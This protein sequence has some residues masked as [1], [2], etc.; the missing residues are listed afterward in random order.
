M[1]TKIKNI[2]YPDIHG[3]LDAVQPL[4][5]IVIKTKSGLL[6]PVYKVEDQ[7]RMKLTPVKLDSEGKIKSLQ[8]QNSTNIKTSVGNISAEFITFYPSGNLRRLFPLNGKL[9]GFWSED[10]EYKLAKSI[11][12]PTPIGDISVKPIYI[13]FYETGELK[14]IT[15][16]PKEKIKINTIDG[17]ISIKTGISFHKSG[18]L[19]SYE[20]ECPIMVK[21]PIGDI[22][23]YD[24][25]PLGINGEKNSLSYNYNGEL[26]TVSTIRSEVTV[27]N[28]L[29]EKFTFS[30]KP[31]PSR[32]SDT[33]FV[34]LPL[35]LEFKQN[36]VVF[37][38]G[39]KT[40]GTV[41]IFAEYKIKPFETDVKVVTSVLGCT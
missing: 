22:E 41:S 21:S 12:I 17:S 5:E 6:I 9:S 29:G 39:F 28:N 25:D 24:P 33:I 18:T 31:Q 34:L 37:S 30:P 7:G 13:H 26:Q 4:E 1:F 40:I 27:I 36:K 19:R 3:V 23:A 38:H 32:C 11:T 8:M 20:P 14:S 16:W 10:N 2:P 35:K 15:F